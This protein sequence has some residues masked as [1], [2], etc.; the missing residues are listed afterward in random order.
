M[1]SSP[2][3][4]FSSFAL[5]GQACH[6]KAK[7]QRSAQVHATQAERGRRKKRAVSPGPEISLIRGRFLEEPW[8]LVTGQGDSDDGKKWAQHSERLFERFFGRALRHITLTM[9]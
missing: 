1:T 3:E 5:V 7:K 6:A 9:P 8:V 2:A 4:K